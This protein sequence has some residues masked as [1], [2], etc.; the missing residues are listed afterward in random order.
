MHKQV[1]I[2]IGIGIDLCFDGLIGHLCTQRCMNLFIG[3]VAKTMDKY[4]SSSTFHASALSYARLLSNRLGGGL[5]LRAT[6]VTC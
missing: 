3:I 6:H 2:K 1:G 5:A 4:H